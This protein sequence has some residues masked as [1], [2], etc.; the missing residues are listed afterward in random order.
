[1]ISNSRRDVK[2]FSPLFGILRSA[3]WLVRTDVS[4]QPIV[5]IYEDQ[6]V[7]PSTAWPLKMVM[8][9]CFETSARNYHCALRKSQ[10]SADLMLG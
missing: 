3:E 9:H 4:G 8:K 2:E 10:K 7:S 6:A 5:P 1:M